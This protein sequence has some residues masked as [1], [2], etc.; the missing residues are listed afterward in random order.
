MI[1]E[2]SVGGSVEW[3]T[4]KSLFDRLGLT[5]E[6]DPAAVPEGGPNA[7]PAATFYRWPPIDGTVA[8]WHGRVWLNPPYGPKAVPFIERMIEHDNGL[9]LIP[10]RTETR[11]FQ[12]AARSA[13]RI[14]F[15]A[16]RLHFVRPDGHQ[17]RASFASVLMAFGDDGDM[18][19]AL[20]RARLGWSVY[21]RTMR[22]PVLENV[23]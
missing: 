22:T 15:L 10:A 1:H 19:H 8:D 21:G 5:F 6:L 12:R 2:K 13:S 9:L 23:A 20:D 3:Y 14:V 16:D 7:V 4:P 11:I 18:L 17:S